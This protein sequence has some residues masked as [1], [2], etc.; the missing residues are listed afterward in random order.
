ML[1]NKLLVFSFLFFA[2]AA[3]AQTCPGPS[4]RTALL[5]L[6]KS[7]AVEGTKAGQIPLTDTCGNQRYAQYVEVNLDTIAYTPT[8]TGN[9]DNL[10]EFVIDPTGAIFYIDWQGNSIEFAGGA[11]ACDA[12]WL[13]IADNACPDAITD[14]I[15]T[16]KYASIGA[17]YVWPTAELL[18]N[19]SLNAVLQVIQGNRNCRLAFYDINSSSWS[20]I[21]HGSNTDVYYMPNDASLLFK[22]SGGTP[23]TPGGTQIDQF[24]INSQDSTIRAYL[25]PN[26]RVDT[27]TIEAI[28]YPDANGVF[29]V[30][31][32]GDIPGL[33][34]NIYNIDGT[35]TDERVVTQDGHELTFSGGTVT[36]DPDGGAGGLVVQ[37]TLLG[38]YLDV[39]TVN[40]TIGNPDANI[41]FNAGEAGIQLNS[42]LESGTG[43]L[44][45]DARTTTKG[46]EYAADYSAGFTDRTLIDR[47][48]AAQM[49]SDSLA[50]GGGG[51]T[52]YNTSSALTSNRSLNQDGFSLELGQSGFSYA[53]GTAEQYI[54]MGGSSP[55]MYLNSLFNGGEFS[56]IHKSEI[57]VVPESINLYTD[58]NDG[59]NSTA[60]IDSAGFHFDLVD[61]NSGQT[62]ILQNNYQYS[63]FG[64]GSGGI[65]YYAMYS[66]TT[67]IMYFD[68]YDQHTIDK[69]SRLQI[70]Y[71]TYFK[72]RG[73]LGGTG[74]YAEMDLDLMSYNL[75]SAGSNSGNAYYLYFD[76]TGY[77]ESQGGTGGRYWYYFSD[78]GSGYEYS[79]TDA[80]ATKSDFKLNYQTIKTILRNDDATVQ[81]EIAQDS[82]GYAAIYSLFSGGD[83]T[84]GFDPGLGGDGLGLVCQIDGQNPNQYQI[85]EGDVNGYYQHAD[86]GH[87]YHTIGVN[88][89]APAVSAG[90][91]AGSG[92]TSNVASA[93]SSDIA[94]RISVTTG[95]SG[96]DNSQPMLSV[97]FDNAYSVTPIVTPSPENENA[98]IVGGWYVSVSTTGFEVFCANTA[99]NALTSSTFALTYTVIQAK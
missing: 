62:S 28:F 11:A 18:V 93:Q 19:D 10:S 64:S 14:S 2:A 85:L 94:G 57:D 60:K 9:T 13:Q 99:I 66:D 98:A 24:E 25:Y 26:T 12:D 81:T 31:P 40:A 71:D 38:G 32:I 5:N 89:A 83:N 17:R 16:Y 92:A 4:Q 54:Y 27:A 61:P 80:V 75:T 30:R 65:N 3:W 23:Q 91:G 46:L 33:G 7:V 20:M 37:N 41:Y 97:T 74:E 6:Q 88:S 50:G 69:R 1:R 86:P 58:T 51:A 21:D 70:G 49:I 77:S 76:T 34:A 84:I 96:I 15:Y 53:G 79:L 22:T 67:G 73:Q 95:S 47:A 42:A 52:L 35:L 68:N 45:T 55:F 90:A 72:Y 29:R 36:I 48:T 43:F 78:P 87:T 8:P 82:F 56:Q 39:S 63:V 44:I 59:R